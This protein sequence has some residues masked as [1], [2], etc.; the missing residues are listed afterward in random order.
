MDPGIETEESDMKR[1]KRAQLWYNP[2]EKDRQN[3]PVKNSGLIDMA[4]SREGRALLE[5]YCR[6]YRV[7]L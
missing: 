1:T 2:V 6:M 3:T 7:K 5:S 4:A